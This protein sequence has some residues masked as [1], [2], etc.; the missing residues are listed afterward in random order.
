MWVQRWV[1]FVK[2][3]LMAEAVAHLKTA[4]PREGVTFRLLRPISGVEA[5]TKVIAEAS[6][7]DPDAQFA[8]DSNPQPP[9]EWMQRWIELS[10]Y[11]G[12]HE[13]YQVQHTVEAEGEPGLWVDRR[14]RWVKDGKRG[15]ALRHW[16]QSPSLSG[17]SLR[18]LTPRTGD[19]ADNILVAEL[20]F[21]S[22]AEFTTGVSEM[23]ATPEGGAWAASVKALEMH[24]PTVELLR[25]VS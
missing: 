24:E 5:G 3:G 1:L 12:I 7:D 2:P 20:T 4:P 22:L 17:V 23:L 6:F 19:K 8:P 25:V 13:L 10:R 11:R 21:D 16:R 18:V 9:N 14:V 15:E